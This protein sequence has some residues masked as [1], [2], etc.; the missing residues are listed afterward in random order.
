MVVWNVLLIE[1]RLC[2]EMVGKVSHYFDLKM[3]HTDT[4]NAAELKRLLTFTPFVT[5]SEDHLGCL[6]VTA[7]QLTLR[8][9]WNWGSNSL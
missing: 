7:D 4:H 6:T 8:A 2:G 1:M 5:L 9:G 3:G